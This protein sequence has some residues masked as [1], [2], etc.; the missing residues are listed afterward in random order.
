MKSKTVRQEEA[1]E[2]Q[3]EYD[4]LSTEQKIA[5]AK[6]RRGESKKELTKLLGE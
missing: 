3:A 2:R 1:K 5:R 6:S 4:A